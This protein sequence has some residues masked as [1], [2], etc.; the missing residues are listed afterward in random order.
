M[1]TMEFEGKTYEVD[2]EGYLMDWSL[3]NEGIAAEMAKQDNL[4]LSDAHWEVI[5]FLRDYFE[6]Y[7]IAP[8]IKILT[9]ELAKKYGKEKGNTK[10][11]YELYP[12]GPAK[13][14]CRYAG[15]PKP[16]GCV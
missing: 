5:R 3:W 9:K 2:E 15:L 12:A 8:M 14:A 6:K 7:Q 4:E 13:Q 11:L 1:P 16:T 10:Y